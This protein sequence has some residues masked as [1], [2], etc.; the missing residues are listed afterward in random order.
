MIVVGA[1]VVGLEYASFMAAMGVE[2]TLIDQRP[3]LLDFVDREIIEALAYH[4]RQMGTTFRLGEKVT[5]VG[6]M[7][8]AIAFSR[9][10]RVARKCRRMRCCTRW[11]A[12]RTEI[13]LRFEAAGLDPDARGKVTVNAEYQTACAAYLCC[14]R[15]DRIPGAGQHFD[16]AGTSRELPHVRRALARHMPALF[17]YGIYTIP[18][19][20]M[21]G[22]TEEKLTANR[23]FRTKWAWRNT[24]SWRRA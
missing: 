22:Q 12:R 18:E 16:G 1:G 5:R 4:L 19:I 11:A 21:V 10:S 20:S 24:T 2:V 13:R 8:S 23:R 15:R 6:L 17:P 9:N 14:G 3:H 7:S